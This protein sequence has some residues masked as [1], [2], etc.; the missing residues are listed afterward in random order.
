MTHDELQSIINARNANL[1]FIEDGHR[2][3]YKGEEIPS[4]S[5]LMEP[6]SRLV[7]GDGTY[8]YFQTG[9]DVHYA[10]QQLLVDGWMAWDTS[11]DGYMNGFMKWSKGMGDRLVIVAIE[12]PITNGIYAGTP[13]IV[14]LLDGEPVIIDMKTSKTNKWNLWRVQLAAY[15]FIMADS[16]RPFQYRQYILNLKGDDDYKFKQVDILQ[17]PAHAWMN[18]TSIYRYSKMRNT[19]K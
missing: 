14:A 3:L 1:E 16:P 2:Y 13:D 7:Y 5:K 11:I 10:I 15:T 8:S 6:L 12:T 9:T 19:V 17:E 18:L 4:V